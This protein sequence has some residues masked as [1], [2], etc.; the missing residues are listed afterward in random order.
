MLVEV[1]A[2]GCMRY[3]SRKKL[4]PHLYIY[5]Y[6]QTPVCVNIW[7]AAPNGLYK[8]IDRDLFLQEHHGISKHRTRPLSLSLSL[9]RV[10]GIQQPPNSMLPPSTH[11][12][13]TIPSLKPP[14]STW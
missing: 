5:V 12:Q 4:K 6:R 1:H 11:T 9:Q 2:P 10:S 14:N 8:V 13:H 3:Q 7:G